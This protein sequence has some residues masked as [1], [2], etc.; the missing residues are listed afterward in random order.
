MTENF[1]VP[2]YFLGLFEPKLAHSIGEAQRA[3]RV[4]IPPAL[5]YVRAGS[6][7][8]PNR[9][10]VS[11]D[12]GLA[13]DSRGRN[14]RNLRSS[15]GRRVGRLSDLFRAS[16]EKGPRASCALSQVL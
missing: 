9:L 10:E 7:A 16:R 13:A 5:T 8:A 1:S 11:R 2:L 4:V 14:L 12:K 3:S 6:R 15:S